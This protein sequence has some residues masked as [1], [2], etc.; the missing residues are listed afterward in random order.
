MTGKV[1]EDKEIYLLAEACEILCEF[2]LKRGQLS[3]ESDFNDIV[4]PG[5]VNEL[6][7]ERREGK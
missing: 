7:R 1:K 5:F 4:E 3:A 2:Y 6:A